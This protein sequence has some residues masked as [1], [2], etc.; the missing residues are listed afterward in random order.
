MARFLAWRLVGMFIVLFFV[1]FVSFGIVSLLPGDYYTS[2]IVQFALQGMSRSEAFE[3]REALRAAAGIDRSWVAQFF[4]WFGGLIRYGDLGVPWDYL[5]HPANGL[6]WTVVIVVSSAIWAWIVG[7]PLAILSVVF[8]RRWI[9]HTIAVV[10]YAAFSFPQYIWG[11]VLF[12]IIYRFI[13]PNIAGPGIWG[14]VSY[15]LRSE[16]LTWYK[17]GSHI[18]HLIPAWILVGAPMLAAVVRHLRA[19]LLDTR[20]ELY[21]LSAR[22]KGLTETRILLRHALPNA[23]NPLISL[24][25]VMIPSLLT[26]SI[27]TSRVLGMPTFGQVL[28]DALK[29][30]NQRVITAGLLVYSVL[31]LA[32]N[33]I[34]DL[35]LLRVDPRIRHD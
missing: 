16:P 19:S 21:L 31:L 35:A 32:A 25:G 18:L 12:W 5:F 14:I 23:L 6:G 15:T 26:G 3:A 29:Q 20:N 2:S 24:T 22:G 1:G 4:I 17:V 9:D 28:L 10:S 13:N 27:L 8:H 11:W 34:A 30:Q 33:V 7:L